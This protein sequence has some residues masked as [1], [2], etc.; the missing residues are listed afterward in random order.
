MGMAPSQMEEIRKTRVQTTTVRL[1]SPVDGIVVARNVAAGQ[2]FDAGTELFQ[3]ADL[4]RVWILAD[5][6]VADGDRIKPGTAARIT[7]AGRPTA[8]RAR[9][10][11]HVLPQFDAATQTFKLRLEADNPGFVLRPDM[12][13][14]VDFEVAYEPALLVPADAVVLSGMRAHVFVERSAGVHEDVD[15]R[16]LHSALSRDPGPGHQ[17]QGGIELLLEARH[18]LAARRV[19]DRA[20]QRRDVAGQPAVSNR[21]LGD[22]PEQPGP[23]EEAVEGIAD[24]LPEP[25]TRRL[26]PLTHEL[27][28]GSEEGVQRNAVPGVD[29]GDSLPEQ[30]V[31]IA[32]LHAGNCRY[33]STSSSYVSGRRSR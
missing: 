20:R 4:Q 1:A 16:D 3:I 7:V 25:G 30:R 11:T 15:K 27:G 29:R 8:V 21:V 28:V 19:H 17:A 32:G 12:F 18:A 2:R 31:E 14:D 22:E 24:L 26:E 9:V 10:S 6:P 5:V 13:V 33:S 23:F